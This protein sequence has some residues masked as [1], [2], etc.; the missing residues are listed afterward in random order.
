MSKPVH[1][2]II[3][4]PDRDAIFMA[5]LA[6]DI[7][8]LQSV[9]FGDGDILRMLGRLRY[10]SWWVCWP[11]WAWPVT[12]LPKGCKWTDGTK[13][14]QKGGEKADA[15]TFIFL[16]VDNDLYINADYGQLRMPATFAQEKTYLRIANYRRLTA[17]EFTTRLR[18][19]AFFHD[20][21]LKFWKSAGLR[22][23]F[24]EPMGLRDVR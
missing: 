4:S 3:W 21:A 23:G 14:H 6:G 2:D 15:E 17:N 1:D 24:I 5:R 11:E 8:K 9:G 10:I 22:Q 12:K 20:C 13:Y 16:P 7:G 19:G 18:M